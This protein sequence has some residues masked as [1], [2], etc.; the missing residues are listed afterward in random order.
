MRYLKKGICYRKYLLTFKGKDLWDHEKIRSVLS[1]IDISGNA[2]MCDEIRNIA[3]PLVFY[4][5]THL[6]I[7]LFESVS[8][9]YIKEI[10]PG[11]HI[12]CIRDDFMDCIAYVTKSGIYAWMNDGIEINLPETLEVY[13]WQ[14]KGDAI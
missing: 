9:S 3:H 4:Y 1:S 2:C 6:Y 14:L 7:E 12:E 11:V 13:S 10:F 5:H 8:V